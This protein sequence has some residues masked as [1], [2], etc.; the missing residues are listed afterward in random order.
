[1]S[2]LFSYD[3]RGIDATLEQASL[4]PSIDSLDE[5]EAPA[6]RGIGSG[7]GNALMRGS[8]ATADFFLTFGKSPAMSDE[9][10]RINAL[11]DD[12]QEQQ[13][14]DAI[15]F[16]TPRPNEVGR[17][18]QV[19]GG[20]AEIV[21]PLAIS[22]GNPAVL[23][24]STTLKTGKELVDENVDATAA[25]GVAAIEG[26]ATYLGFKV[27]IAGKTLAGRL[28][29]GAAGNA[30]VG[31]A[32]R[33]AAGATLESQGYVTQAEQYKQ[34]I[35]TFSTDLLIGA[36]FG[37]THHL[38]TPGDAPSI[39]PKLSPTDVDA[40]LTARNAKNFAEGTTP[41]TPADLRTEVGH[42]EANEA[43]LTQLSR[44]GEVN[45]GD[46]VARYEGS[47][48]KDASHVE[49]SVK[50][51]KLVESVEPKDVPRAPE[52]VSKPAEEADSGYSVAEG[53]LTDEQRAR[54]G[55]GA[56]GE[57]K[58]LGRTAAGGAPEVGWW[59]ATR[60]LGKVSP[61][62]GGREP[63][64]V[65]RGGG[66][67]VAA[68][69]FGDAAL[70]AKTGHPSSGLGVFFTTSEAQASRWGQVRPAH[71]DIRNPKVIPNEDLP[72]FDSLEEAAAFRKQLQTE[73][74]DGIVIKNSHLGSPDWI[75]AFE[76]KQV[77]HG[78]PTPKAS[79]AASNASPAAGEGGKAASAEPKAEPAGEPVAPEASATSRLAESQPDTPVLV[80]YDAEGNPVMSTLADAHA[81]S[82]AQL[83]R[84]LNDAKAYEA[85]ITCFLGRGA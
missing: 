55:L 43:A 62:G 33:A 82:Q 66:R 65:Y 19:L 38:L 21:P 37:G 61:D 23:I 64:T 72:G 36:L 57:P 30:A 2:D 3:Q 31:S 26:A 78:A 45:V 60:I 6:F 63:R 42:Q 12:I 56:A 34:D 54:F 41:G 71:L 24:G 47:E 75:V 39:N 49:E 22:A 68:E 76:P 77:I 32:S 18:G 9:Q 35:R 8:A 10:E 85:A 81:E 58:E 53:E 69:H 50:L 44:G 4:A 74:H 73:G 79:A 16:W 80:G 17:V 29:T 28:A 14:H 84:D 46:V 48:F 83:A 40:I 67:E 70:G 25:G 52:Y 13:R 1:M 15:D 20:L 11:A 5:I 27:P 59:D 7:I 51:A